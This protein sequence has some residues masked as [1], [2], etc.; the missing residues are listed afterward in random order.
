MGAAR[1]CAVGV[2]VLD[3]PARGRAGARRAAGRRGAR[4]YREDAPLIEGLHAAL[5]P[6][7]ESSDTMPIE[8]DMA[9]EPWAPI[10]AVLVGLVLAVVIWR[11]S[12]I[13]L[14]ALAGAILGAVV[15]L[16]SGEYITDGYSG[17]EACGWYTT[18]LIGG[19][20]AGNTT[21][22]WWP[23]GRLLEPS[24]RLALG[25]SVASRARGGSRD[26]R[27][28]RG[29]ELALTRKTREGLI[30]GL[31]AIVNTCGP[32]LAPRLVPSCVAR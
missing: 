11:S 28:S 22:R 32:N 3:V 20:S 21:D 18:L 19:S 12:W 26:R 25:R 15:F 23:S 2:H 1:R 30:A 7:V 13:V 9:V 27:R 14:V 16:P 4:P 8:S 24:S 10:T 29:V 31:I 5:D 17:C 6:V